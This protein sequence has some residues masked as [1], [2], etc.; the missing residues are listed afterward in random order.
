MPAPLPGLLSTA[1]KV[2]HVIDPEF[3]AVITGQSGQLNFPEQWLWF[4]GAGVQA[5]FHGGQMV[6]VG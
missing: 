2:V 6:A 1:N 3:D 5:E 4:N